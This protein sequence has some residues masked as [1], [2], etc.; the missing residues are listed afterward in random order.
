MKNKYTYPGIMSIQREQMARTEAELR[1]I[2]VNVES[3]LDQLERKVLEE[4]SRISFNKSPEDQVFR[5]SDITREVNAIVAS[6][7]IDVA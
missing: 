4:N 2:S 1:Y 6:G 7:L 3:I 5:G